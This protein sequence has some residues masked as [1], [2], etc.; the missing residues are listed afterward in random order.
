MQTSQ[1]GGSNVRGGAPPAPRST[2]DQAPREEAWDALIAIDLP[3]GVNRAAVHPHRA[4]RLHAPCHPLSG[5]ILAKR[6]A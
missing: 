3:P 6:N 2:L 1:C 4:A 5:R